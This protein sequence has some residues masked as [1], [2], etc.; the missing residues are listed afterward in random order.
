MRIL[1]IGFVVAAASIL[2]WHYWRQ[3]QAAPLIVSGFV[4]ADEVRVGSRVGGRVVGVSVAEGQR[5][6]VGDTLFTLDAF[7]WQERLAE[8]RAKLAA[9]QAEHARRRSG[10]LPQE[11]AQAQAKRDRASATL[12]KLVAGPR[13]Q[14]I[15][16]AGEQLNIAKADLELAES[17]YERVKNLREEASAAKV[18]Y[19]QA[20]R[21]LKRSRAALA[22]AVSELALLEEGTRAEEVAE[23]RAALAEADEALQLMQRGYREEDITEAAA[24]VA[25]AE[26]QVAAIQ[27]QMKELTVLSPCDCVVEAVGLRPGD[28]VPPNAPT[29]TLLDVSRLWVRTYVPELHLGKVRLGQRVPVRVDSIPNRRFAARITFLATQAEFTPRNIQTLEERSKQVFRTKVTLEEGADILRVGM[30]ADILFDEAAEP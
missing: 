2:G 10:Y 19:D 11:V 8:A 23:A 9:F 15:E 14:V 16:I 25:A 29:L 27:T 1:T 20:L 6:R 5:V 21:T 18:E 26:A 3:G 12:Q 17:E 22:T 13:S 24:Q 7:D 28:L 4:E 30:G